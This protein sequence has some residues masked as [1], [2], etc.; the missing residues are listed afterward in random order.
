MRRA[1]RRRRHV[2]IRAKDDYGLIVLPQVIAD[3]LHVLEDWLLELRSWNMPGRGLS[4]G[5]MIRLRRDLRL[6]LRR[7]VGAELILGQPHHL[8]SAIAFFVLKPI[9]DERA[10]FGAVGVG[11]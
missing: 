9:E 8:L 7:Q 5:W 1:R 6:G 10:E 3:H 4:G 2:G 11:D